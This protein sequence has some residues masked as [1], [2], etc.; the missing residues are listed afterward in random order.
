MTVDKSCGV[1]S[2]IHRDPRGRPVLPG[3]GTPAQQ[4]FELGA[5]G[6]WTTRTC[7]GTTGPVACI[8]P[9]I[10]GAK[11]SIVKVERDDQ[12]RI[13]KQ[14]CFQA[15]DKPS[16]C[17]GGYPHERRYEYGPDGRVRAETF[18]D[19]KGA[20]ALGLGAAQIERKYTSIGKTQT[21]SYLDKDGNPVLNKLGFA[22]M[23]YAYDI[24]QRVSLIQ[25]QGVDGQPRGVKSLA[26]GGIVWPPGAAK[27]SVD[28]ETDGKLANVYLG[29]DDKVVKRVECTDASVPC[30]RR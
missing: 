22:S 1:T 24:Q 20:P 26:H 21:E 3:P 14:R 15:P 18:L 9:K 5:D 16:P 30:Y 6:L 12:G 25:V 19:E 11:G 8:F 27:M 23:T 28:R 2:Q 29:P 4:T 13:V 7:K 10:N 17:E